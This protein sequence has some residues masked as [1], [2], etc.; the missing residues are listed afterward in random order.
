MSSLA[1]K[2][3]MTAVESSGAELPAD[4]KVAPATSG[5]KPKTSDILSNAG[6]KY[7]SQTIARP[8]NRVKDGVSQ[9]LILVG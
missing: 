7:S 6:T 5:D 2:T 4:I 9:N 1:T 8:L 3:P